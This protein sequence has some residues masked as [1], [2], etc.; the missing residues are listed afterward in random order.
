MLAER[1]AFRGGTAIN[2]LLF[3]SPLRYS[4]DIDLVQLSAEPIGP[5][6][7][8]IRDA[9]AWLGKCQRKQA[10]HSSHLTFRF[11]PE[12]APGS[13]L[14]LKVEINTREHQA[15]F[16]VC[17][18]PFNISSRWYEGG[19]ELVSYTREELFA[20]KLRALLQRRKGRDLFDLSVGLAQLGLDVE[21]VVYAF[22]HYLRQ[23]GVSIT[24]AEAEQRMIEKLDSNLIEDVEPLL[25]ADTSFSEADALA[26][27]ERVWGDLVARIPGAA[28][29]L[30]EE[31]IARLR[32]TRYPAL[33]SEGIA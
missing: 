10:G 3:D 27:F 5:T 30:S 8:A 4:E 14:K 31:S 9:L 7:D 16:G 26:G 21:K 1:L 17:N 33:F 28:W 23:E 25:R 22:Q 19:T 6:I 29:R 12:A 20:T 32:E 18:Y 2:K 15:C 11:A 13:T 24:R